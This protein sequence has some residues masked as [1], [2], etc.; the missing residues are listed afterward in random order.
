MSYIDTR[1]VLI[2]SRQERKHREFMQRQ[3]AI[4]LRLA[5]PDY[6]EL[7][8]AGLIPRAVPQ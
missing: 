6:P 8:G 5:Y 3:L 1:G 4:A 2:E 7:R